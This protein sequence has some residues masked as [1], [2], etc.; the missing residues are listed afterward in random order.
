[1]LGRALLRGLFTI[2]IV[3]VRLRRNI[4][5][6]DRH[7]RGRNNDDISNA[8]ELKNFVRNEQPLCRSLVYI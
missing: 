3:K 4:S 6:E 5:A 8:Q 2:G 7:W 1:M